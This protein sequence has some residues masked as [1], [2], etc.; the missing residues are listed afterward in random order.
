MHWV[1]AIVDDD[2]ASLAAIAGLVDALGFSTLAFHDPAA[3]LA[4]RAVVEVNALI[5]DFRL[6]GLN[7]L[8]L[9]RRLRHLGISLPT[10]LVTAYPD[11]ATRLQAL[12]EGVRA[13]LAKP[14]SPE[15]L[16]ACLRPAAD[17]R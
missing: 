3:F 16:L 15:A 4:A 11:E 2:A 8:A 10:V 17:P 14:V 12:K 9:H 5:A 7:G 6:P 1:V 13:Y